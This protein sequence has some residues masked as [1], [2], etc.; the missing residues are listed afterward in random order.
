LSVD[1]VWNR[2]VGLIARILQI[3]VIVAGMLAAPAQAL[4]IAQL[5]PQGEVAQVRQVVI[6]FDSAVTAFGDAGARAPVTLQCGDATA[7]KGTGRWTTERV[8]SYRFAQDLPPGVRCTVQAVP[9]LQSTNG[10]ALTGPTQFRFN[11]GGPFVQSVMPYP[12]SRIDEDQAF[13]LRLNGPASPE[14]I[15]GRVW[16]GMQG[17]G[18]RIGVRLIEGADRD[19]L[20]RSRQLE[21][22]ARADPLRVVTLACNR[23]LTPSADVQLV[24]GKGV[25]TPDVAGAGTGIANTV[26]K[27]F[28]FTVREPFLADFQCERENAQADCLPI[29]PLRLAFNAPVARSLAEGIRLRAGDRVFKPV[30]DTDA[31]TD[32]AVDGV[33]FASVLPASTRFQLELP[34]DLKDDAGRSL[35]NA[36]SFPRTVATGPLPPLVKFAAAPFGIVERL[37]ESDGQAVLPVT[38]RNVEAAL[39]GRAL[40]PVPTGTASPGTV[41]DLQLAT[42]AQIIGWYRKLQRYEDFRIPREVAAKDVQGPLPAALD[43]RDQD[44]VQSRMVSLLQG[45][46]GVRSL[47]LP[48]PTAADPRP[49]EVIGIPLSPGFHV[50]EIASQVLGASLLD[51]RHG[52][53]RTLFV[54]TSALVTNL[55]VH[56]K[57]GRE[58]ALAWVTTLDGGRPVFNAQV[59]VSDCHGRE[60]ATGLTDRQGIARFAGLDPQ[61]PTCNDDGGYSQ[62]YFVSARAATNPPAR[63]ARGG[64]MQ[65]LAFTWSDWHRGIEPWRFQLPTNQEQQPAS[66]AHTVFDRTLLRA[67][68][69]V[70]MKHILRVETGKG[71]AVPE[72]HPDTLLITHVGSGQQTTQALAWRTTATGGLSAESVLGIPVA[73]KLGLYTVSLRHGK[74]GPEWS[75]GRFRV[76]AFRLPVLKGSVVPADRGPL[77]DPRDLPVNVQIAYVAGGG[78][79]GMPVQVSALLR[80]KSLQFDGFDGFRFSPPRNLQDRSTSGTDDSDEEVDAAQD[81][82]VVADKL[83]LTLDRN[84]VGQ[85]KVEGLPALRQAQ[86]LLL[87]VSYADPSGEVQTLRSNQTLWPSAVVAGIKTEDWVSAGNSLRV[88]VLALDVS[89]KPQA[90]IPLQVHAFARQVTSSRKRI[91]GGFYAYDNHT[92]VKDLGPVCSGRSDNRGRLRC[93]AKLDLPGEV[94]LVATATDAQG[95]KSVAA[96]SVYV[97]RHGEVWFG[98]QNHDRMDVL[99]EKTGYAPGETARFQVRMPFRHAT[100][101][102]AVEREGIVETQVVQL[103]GDDP[104]ITLKVKPQW[105]PNVYVSVL[106]VRGRLREVPWY[107][108]FSWGYKA[109]RVWWTAFRYGGEVVAPT[110]LV[111]LSKPAFRLGVAEIQVG[112]QAHR[113]DVRV[114]AD[115][116]SYPVRGKAQVTITVKRPDGQPA[117]NA[118]VAIA[119][120]DEALL[121]LMPNTSWDLLDAMLQRRA[122]GVETSTAQME[123]IGRRHYGRKAVPAGGGGGHSASRELLDTLLLWSPRV[124]LD[125]Q[126]KAQI[127]VPLN[128]ALTRFRIVAVADAGVGLFG[129]GFAQIRATQDLQ[130]I[131]G[132]PPLVRE[133]DQYQARFTLRNTTGKAMQIALM[134]QADLV[135]LAPQTVAIPAGEARE[136]HW[137]VNAPTQ[138]G[139]TRLDAI[140]WDIKARDSVSGAQDGLKAVQ[141]LL[142]AVPLAVQQATLVQLDADYA[143]DVRIPT[144][145]LPGQGGLALALQPRLADGLPAI[146]D[147]FARYPFTCLEQLASKAIGLHDAAQWQAL[148]AQLPTYLDA[149]GLA[150]YFPPREGEAASGSDTLTAYLIAT[151]DEA[152]RLRPEF[153]LDEASRSAMVAGLIAFV[154]GRITRTVWSPRKDLDVRKLA[155]IEALSR[156]GKAQARMLASITIAPNQWPTHALIDWLLVLQ[157]V[158]DVPDRARRLA[159]AQ[160][161]LRARIDMQ[162]TRMSFSTEQGD[163][164]W[165]LMQ[166]ADL[167]A[168]RLLLA[169]MD[170]PAWKDDMGRLASGFIARQQR[171]TWRTTTA[172]AWG[173][174][175]LEQFSAQFE[176]ADVAGITRATLGGQQGAVDWS[177]VTRNAP[178]AGAGSTQ[179]SSGFGAGPGTGALRNNDLFLSW[180]MNGPSQTLRVTQ[181][182]SG[183]PWLSVQALAAVPRTQAFDGGYQIRKSVTAV[184]QA[185]P[186]LPT[187]HYTRGDILRVTLQV[188]AGA[189]MTW[190]VVSDPI[191]AG[192][193]ILGSGLGRDSLIATQG[194]TTGNRGVWPAFEERSFE[195]YRAYYAYL[196]KGGMTTQYTIR[197][198]NAGRFV[199]PPTRVEAL[200]APEM[201]G[202][203]PNAPVVVEAPR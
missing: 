37:A 39:Q 21:R 162:G 192:A 132:L 94:E 140:Q 171:G 123:I 86:D 75:S 9:D 122:W 169:V 7:A 152:A 96:S 70:S 77:I 108:F 177:T 57:L 139:Q 23:R 198:N 196:P 1:A 81:N 17:I 136:L 142:P 36:A 13:I 78:A 60:V 175:A 87:E 164:W 97:T 71:L 173:M 187:G 178:A 200:Y 102:V 95:R 161:N 201:F 101:L 43:E 117:A 195:A 116:E 180:P 69:T 155:A 30:F 128:D 146:R 158:Q 104:T 110:A 55:A 73:A 165:W 112:K 66:R 107:S 129:S 50:V 16:C 131:S 127:T 203:L 190:A 184:Q 193:S 6:T 168:A 12:G 121:E 174:L 145:A 41:R 90:D 144:G 188:I 18:E 138:T 84:G 189:D 10:S 166:G 147:W 49:F 91:V 114:V 172:N 20:L 32:A 79:A 8:W 74:D 40:R 186:S 179:T 88:Q 103:R 133:G 31:G 119:A 194:E 92:E 85:V 4:Q 183:K 15:R 153:A 52:A 64:A 3:G 29:R 100:A 98:G 120:V 51:A 28:D 25:A 185:D 197:L 182:G 61:A 19:A 82:R 170:N 72:L 14:S 44:G 58:N 11:T 199:L 115:K 26:E 135:T 54:R 42:D 67:G 126:G 2:H 65:D 149:D 124:Q 27:R 62:A 76:E 167:N 83:P 137:S 181:Q 125:A 157:R 176:K 154:E 46:S 163:D 113:L 99:P 111:D 47:D 48:R 141:R 93:D 34:P 150:S 45:R 22:Q 156:H 56:F 130:I 80:H 33:E 5:T 118:E 160:H 59:R 35:R 191:P 53:P 134:P 151:S 106:S 24:F 109:P 148:R 89:G 159:E 38:L 105:A 202:E 68:E 63:S 143:L